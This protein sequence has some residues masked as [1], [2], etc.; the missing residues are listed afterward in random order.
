MNKRSCRR[1]DPS[2]LQLQK[3]FIL[4]LRSDQDY[5]RPFAMGHFSV[6]SDTYPLVICISLCSA[7]T[8]TFGS[9]NTMKWATARVD[10]TTYLP[11]EPSLNCA[12]IYPHHDE[13][14]SHRHTN[15]QQDNQRGIHLCR[16]D[17]ICL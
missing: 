4:G 3:I 13:E 14:A 17:K 8:E 15:A 10:P 7:M 2:F 6:S 1:D 9:V 12:T 11:T 16:Q 5:R